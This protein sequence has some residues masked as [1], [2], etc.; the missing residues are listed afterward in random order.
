M[1]YALM[2]KEAAAGLANT[3]LSNI[4]SAST[5]NQLYN[6]PEYLALLQAYKNKTAQ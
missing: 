6:S 2:N 4:Q 5:H 3:G 1:K